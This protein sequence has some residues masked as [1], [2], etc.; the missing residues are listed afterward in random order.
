MC[1]CVCV[2]SYMNIFLLYSGYSISSK[3]LK[4]YVAM[5]I[6]HVLDDNTEFNK[7]KQN[8]KEWE[9]LVCAFLFVHFSL[10]SEADG[11]ATGCYFLSRTITDMVYIYLLITQNEIY[12]ALMQNRN[13]IYLISYFTVI[14]FE[15]RKTN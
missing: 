6:T 11:E 12:L 13:I 7:T 9:L 4:K 8:T 5:K 1:K 2:M 3:K 15:I 14:I 10:D